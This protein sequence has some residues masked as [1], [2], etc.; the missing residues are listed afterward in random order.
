[1][2]V[3]VA[4]VLMT[5]WNEDTIAA[6][7]DRFYI[8]TH[9]FAC[10]HTLNYASMYAWILIITTLTKVVNVIDMMPQWNVGG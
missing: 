6:A 3:S 5:E 10:M 7:F 1:M 8:R 2:G 4:F 9:N